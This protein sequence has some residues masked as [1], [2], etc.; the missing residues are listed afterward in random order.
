M[1]AFFLGEGDSLE[2]IEVKVP[3]FF[4]YYVLHV[5]CIFTNDFLGEGIICLGV[6]GFSLRLTLL[7]AILN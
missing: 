6:S 7:T 2:L 1:L 3:V 4:I 5:K